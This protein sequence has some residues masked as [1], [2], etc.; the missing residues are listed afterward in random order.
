MP[1][2]AS[3]VTETVTMLRF[4]DLLRDLE[5]NNANAEAFV[6]SA[7]SRFNALCESDRQYGSIFTKPAFDR[8]VITASAH[9]A[10]REANN[11]VTPWAGMPI[12]LKDLLD[13]EGSVTTGGSNLLR[14]APPAEVNAPVV[15]LLRAAGLVSLGRT[16]LTEFAYSPMAI[17]PH[18]GTPPNPSAP[19]RIPGG[20]SSGSAAAIAA[21]LVF[22]AIGSDTGGSVRIPA[23][24][25]GLYGFRPTQARV[26]REG[27]LALSQSF[28]SI[29]PLASSLPGVR[30]LDAVMAGKPCSEV[31]R[32]AGAKLPLVSPSSLRLGIP[33]DIVCDEMD[34][35][36]SLGWARCRQALEEAGVQLVEFDFPELHEIAAIYQS[37]SY[38]AIEAYALHRERI[39]AHAQ[40]IDPFILAR[41]LK[42]KD[43]SAARYIDLLVLRERL[44]VSAARRIDDL[45]LDGWLMPTIQIVPPRLADV[46]ETEDYFR[47]LGKIV[48]NPS[49]V[50]FLDVC[51]L[52]VP[53]HTDGELPVSVTLVGGRGA[54]D[55]LLEVA[56][57][58]DTL[59]ERVRQ[60]LEVS[61]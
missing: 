60:P 39:E 9:D 44:S 37:P 59:L 24:F 38:V 36:M 20:S 7:E 48:R 31:V 51:A 57:A 4:E 54:D 33:R 42:G 18:F 46:Q 11:A 1:P 28:D 35:G 30:V 55:G 23:A 53:V 16:N 2:T 6:R 40:A 50:N 17:N 32:L 41:L 43:V 5:C 12:A 21:G 10:M 49:I 19:G 58:L 29:G 61:K 56:S 15:D 45:G 25:C 47:E 8:A 34:A 14:S 13:E 52:A 22:G 3:M 26:S 27:C